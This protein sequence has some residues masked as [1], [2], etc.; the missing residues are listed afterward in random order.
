MSMLYILENM[1]TASA[2][3]KPTLHE[4]C[5]CLFMNGVLFTH[6]QRTLSIRAVIYSYLRIC[7]SVELVTLTLTY[8][9]MTSSLLALSH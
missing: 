3:S 7:I 9:T 5:Q 8:P 4:K 2:T 6:Q 1:I